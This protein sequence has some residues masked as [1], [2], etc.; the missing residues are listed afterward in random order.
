MS[1][2]P[3][4]KFSSCE[5]CSNITMATIDGVCN[6]CVDQDRKDFRLVKD[7]MRLNEAMS[8]DELSEKTG[9]KLKRIRAWIERGRLQV[10][11]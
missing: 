2:S 9:I 3:L 7:A 1:K 10:V 6:D 4:D 8:T 5:I 11:V